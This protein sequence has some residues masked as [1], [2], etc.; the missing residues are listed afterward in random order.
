MNGLLAGLAALVAAAGYLAIALPAPAPEPRGDLYPLPALSSLVTPTPK[1][2]T[3]SGGEPTF[4][5]PAPV[6]P[7][8]TATAE[9][10]AA[11][12]PLRDPTAMVVAASLPSPRELEPDS[13][14]A[15]LLDAGWPPELVEEA[16]AIAWK[17][18]R[19]HPGST[20]GSHV[21]LFQLE[22][23][24]AGWQGWFAY[25]GESEASWADPVLN[26]RVA[27]CVYRYDIARGNRPWHQW[28]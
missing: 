13:I 24:A 5:P 8:P 26:A 11:P 15:W 9:P 1:P 22:S 16:K 18:S 14:D 17:E 7:E 12:V 10:I 27:L 19:W 23:S 21:G 4:P 2:P 3:F 25:C 28:R 6:K 20:N